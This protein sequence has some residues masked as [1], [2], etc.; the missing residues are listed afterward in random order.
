MSSK[1]KEKVVNQ[2]GS[3][4]TVK[5]KG[6]SSRQETVNEENTVGGNVEGFIE[7]T[8]RFDDYDEIEFLGEEY[9]VPE[10]E[11]DSDVNVHDK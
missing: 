3:E 2:E 9:N 5:G 4:K 1:G 8:E 10:D 6:E 7:I 11:D